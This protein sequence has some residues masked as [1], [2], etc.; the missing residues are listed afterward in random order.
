[1]VTSVFPDFLCNPLFLLIVV[2]AYMFGS[3]SVEY[4]HKLFKTVNT[5]ITVF[6]IPM[7]FKE[8]SPVCIIPLRHDRTTP[9]LVNPTATFV[10]PELIDVL[11]AA[12]SVKS[13]DRQ[14][15]I[16]SADL[17]VNELFHIIDLIVS[18]SCYRNTG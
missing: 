11:E 9:P 18:S 6:I 8:T 15:F 12:I 2:L 14:H 4:L 17:N 16:C 5:T 1:M 13:N 3:S 7:G 10:C